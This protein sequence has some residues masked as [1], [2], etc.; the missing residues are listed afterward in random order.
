MRKLLRSLLILSGVVVW[1]L[2]PAAAAAD[3]KTEYKLSTVFGKPYP[4]GIAGERWAELVKERT[5]GR[6]NIK[7]YP[8][9][10]L[11]GGDQAKEFG[12]IRQGAIDMAIGSAINW[13]LQLKELGIFCL[14]FLLPDHKA[15]DAVTGGEVGRALFKLLEYND[16]LPLAWGENGFRQLSN[17]KKDIR[18]PDDLTGLRI[19]VAGSPVFM[20]TFAA[21]GAAPVQMSWADAVPALSNGIVDGLETAFAVFALAKL[22][23]AGHQKFLTLW[24]YAADPLIFAVSKDAWK[25]WRPED[26]TA[27]RESAIQ[28]ARENVAAARK[29][30][31]PPDD[32]GIREVEALGVSVIRPTDLEKAEFRKAIRPVY[33]K[34]TQQI[35]PALVKKTE[36]AVARRK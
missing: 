3:Y 7:C 2:S 24:N 17:S 12:A 33:E 27:V 28:A 18:K 32:A 23:A 4:W 19:R 35:G 16:I 22:P 6:I 29:G 5:G 1:F 8:G 25:S 34:W 9:T 10:S 11:V 26:Q 36:E 20:D 31:I 30:L 14:P 13:S 15:I 21:L